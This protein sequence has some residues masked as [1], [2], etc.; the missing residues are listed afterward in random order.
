[1]ESSM[2]GGTLSLFTKSRWIILI[3][4]LSL[5]PRANYCA[6]NYSYMLQATALHVNTP[7]KGAVEAQFTMSV[8]ANTSS[9]GDIPLSDYQRNY[10]KYEPENVVSKEY[11]VTG[12][13]TKY[14][15]MS[16][17]AHTI[18]YF[19]PTIGSHRVPEEDR[20][21]FVQEHYRKSYIVPRSRNTRV[22]LGESV[23]LFT[24]YNVRKRQYKNRKKEW[25]FNGE[26]RPEWYGLNSIVIPHA[27]KSHEGFYECDIM[28]IRSGHGITT[29]RLIVRECPNGMWGLPDCLS[30]C[31]T[32]YFGGMCD[33][34][35]GKCICAPGFTGTNCENECPAAA[36]GENCAFVCQPEITP[37]NNDDCQFKALCQKDPFGCTCYSGFT[38]FNCNEYCSGSSFGPKCALTCH[39]EPVSNCSSS[40]TQC[41]TCEAGYSGPGCQ[42][43]DNCDD[44][45][46]GELCTYKC[47][48]KDGASCH[49]ETGVC[50]NGECA[51]GWGD[52]T[53]TGRCQQVSLLWGDWSS[54]S[55]CDPC[56]GNIKWR[57]RICETPPSPE[58]YP[59]LYCSGDHDETS[60]CSGP[61]NVSCSVIHV[62]NTGPQKPGENVTFL[63]FTKDVQPLTEFWIDFGDNSS[64]LQF[65]W[66]ASSMDIRSYLTRRKQIS[67]NLMSFNTVVIRHIYSETSIYTANIT[68][69]TLSALS[70]V[71]IMDI[72]CLP[73]AVKIKGGGY[74]LTTAVKYRKHVP[75]ML[76]A[77]LK[78]DCQHKKTTIYQWQ[79]YTVSNEDSTSMEA[80]DLQVTKTFKD[81]RIPEFSLD[82]GLYIFKFTVLIID[83]DDRNSSNSDTVWLEIITS[84]LIPR[85]SGGSLR[86]TGW[87][88]TLLFDASDSEDPDF[89][90]PHSNL[91]FQWLC[92]QQSE[93]FPEVVYPT[94]IPRS[95]G[96]FNNGMYLSNYYN[97]VMW[98]LNTATLQS[99]TTYVIRLLLSQPGK[100]S[101]FTDQTIH[102][103][104]NN[105]PNVQL[106]CL[107]NCNLELNPSQR[108]I[109]NGKCRD[110]ALKLRPNYMWY[111]KTNKGN[112]KQ[113]L[114]WDSETTTG[115]FKAYLSIK[116]GVFSSTEPEHYSIGLK[117]TSRDGGSSFAEYSF[118]TNSPPSLGSCNITPSVGTVL[119]TKFT[120]VCQGFTDANTPLTYKFY[121]VTGREPQHSDV[122]HSPTSGPGS[123]LY[124]GP[125][126]TLTDFI[127]PAG[128]ESKN[129][130]VKI[131]VK[132][133]DASGASIETSL[134]VQVLEPETEDRENVL[135]ELFDLASGTDSELKQ[136]LVS[137]LQGA[138]QIVT[139]ATSILTT[140]DSHTDT[141]QREDLSL[142]RKS[143]KAKLREE[144]ILEL[145][146]IEAD[147]LDAVQ[148]KASALLQ[149][150]QT[151]EEVTRQAQISVSRE[152][153][154]IG[155]FLKKR[156]H[157]SDDTE[158]LEETASVVLSCINNIVDA[159]SLSALSNESDHEDINAEHNFEQDVVEAIEYISDAILV[160]KQAGEGP[161]IVESHS[162][163]LVLKKEE[164]WNIGDSELVDNSGASFKLPAADVL[165]DSENADSDDVLVLKMQHFQE[166][167]FSWGEGGSAITSTISGLEVMKEDSTLIDV[168]NLTKPVKI[169]MPQ[170]NTD[171]Y[172]G[173]HVALTVSRDT[174]STLN[175]AIDSD[176]LAILIVVNSVDNP[177]ARFGVY[178]DDLNIQK[179]N[180]SFHELQRETSI[181]NVSSNTTVFQPW[182]HF[183]EGTYALSINLYP[184]E[185]LDE[186]NATVSVYTVACMFW[187][188]VEE[189]WQSHGCQVDS[190]S[191]IMDVKCNCNH[192]S[193]F[194]ISL[195]PAPYTIQTAPTAPYTGTLSTAPAITPL[196]DILDVKSLTLFE[197]VTHPIILAVVTTFGIYFTIM[198]WALWKDTDTRDKVVVL[199]DND[200]FS[201]Y[202]YHV[203]VFTGIRQGAGTTSNVAI[204][205]NGLNSS[206][207]THL[208]NSSKSKRRVLQRGS[209][210]RFLLTTH[211]YLGDLSCIRLW[212][213]NSGH[214]PSWYIGHI[215]VHDLHANIHWVFIAN[216]WL[217]AKTGLLDI[218]LP[219][220]SEKELIN[221]Q[222]SFITRW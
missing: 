89:E 211:E 104:N 63:I 203:T 191:T 146:N 168:K 32:C 216:A 114:D 219:C 154:E 175:I 59:Y 221:L 212:H 35:N 87:N 162:L 166:N 99:N 67:L 195:L 127:L 109:L 147:S 18:Y 93:A 64:P 148:Q 80:Y 29:V 120:I 177:F 182:E 215:L 208:L 38:N 131:K 125:D 105:P 107:K 79:V 118:T 84:E 149:L 44:G 19:Q 194:G 145:E 15:H 204:T 156:S 42:V 206:S 98:K 134:N 161:S 152:M 116:A 75:F 153:K 171:Q 68:G 61:S 83:T 53:G 23:T 50:S 52:S 193:F 139:S 158:L 97:N 5:N 155:S 66:P 65:F 101:A 94:M 136:L 124:H 173:F 73:P 213:D 54:W 222:N 196:M 34:K 165:F 188:A 163:S 108:L 91:S 96:C 103:L 218:T 43:P 76:S 78:T 119:T 190:N 184:E 20:I 77:H 106:R 1:M 3:M 133:A 31:P 178:L 72:F 150:T 117:V 151:E 141:H 137:D 100:E 164:T 9:F 220:S 70:E 126:D 74:N 199:E 56:Q 183:G 40:P 26:Y 113:N 200:P 169:T 58:S 51:L 36:Y 185:N 14:I 115:R 217:S 138:T 12:I 201:K 180:S 167:L 11:M 47:H 41:V 172:I 8:Q 181:D 88:S 209:V 86:S 135:M 82:Y 55:E 81:I 110:C 111:L 45:F 17:T 205:I 189:K 198:V 90:D 28:Y 21:I 6:E 122:K 140:E 143:R 197:I 157:K 160:N 16:L 144:M 2:I 123:L 128:I 202:R 179:E 46:F 57:S 60:P 112:T 214:S 4:W 24:E 187:S 92:R 25:Y 33:P 37:R 27:M 174:K 7:S 210:D 49:R 142:T 130:V 10:S 13:R 192:L 121:A 30:L 85:I 95:G 102:I 186:V 159:A 62:L 207:E 48:C 129:Y 132:V 39:C 69:S 170:H 71:K 176:E 22:A